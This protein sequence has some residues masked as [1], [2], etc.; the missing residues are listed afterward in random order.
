MAK[1]PMPAASAAVSFDVAEFVDLKAGCCF[2]SSSTLRWDPYMKIKSLGGIENWK[3]NHF[4]YVIFIC[5]LAIF[6]EFS[7]FSRKTAVIICKFTAFPAILWNS[8]KKRCKFRENPFSNFR[9]N[10]I[11]FTK[12]S[13]KSQKMQN[14]IWFFFWKLEIR[15]L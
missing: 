7:R 15:Y 1:A 5:K 12:K 10:Y 6:S 4:N 11:N 3:L 8:D 9:Q 14:K 2:S 13:R